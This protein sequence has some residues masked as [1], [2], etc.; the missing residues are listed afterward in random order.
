ML[1]KHCINRKPPLYF[2]KNVA[3]MSANSLP[4]GLVFI[5][6]YFNCPLG[7]LTNVLD[8]TFCFS[9]IIIY[10]AA[11]FWETICY[12]AAFLETFARSLLVSLLKIET[13]GSSHYSP[14]LTYYLS[15]FIFPLLHKSFQGRGVKYSETPEI[16]SMRYIEFIFLLF[17]DLNLSGLEK[18]MQ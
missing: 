6:T 17:L 12:S 10:N 15:G 16:R 2:N 5:A 1:S 13:H 11:K 8:W 7:V 4:F 9:A 14:I 3:V 18:H